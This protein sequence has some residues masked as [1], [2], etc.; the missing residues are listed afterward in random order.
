[1]SSSAFLHLLS[2]VMTVSVSVCLWA[3]MS[4][5]CVCVEYEQYDTILYNSLNCVAFRAVS[6]CLSLPDSGHD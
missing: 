5:L 4:V 1:M 2:E 3:S 6:V